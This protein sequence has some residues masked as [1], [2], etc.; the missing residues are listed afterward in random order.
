MG[1]M[2]FF[3]V[4]K[5]RRCTNVHRLVCHAVLFGLEAVA[6]AEGDITPVEIGVGDDV[7]TRTDVER[8]LDGDGIEFVFDTS[9]TG[10]GESDVA[11]VGDIIRP[12]TKVSTKT[13]IPA[14]VAGD[15]ASPLI[16]ACEADGGKAIVAVPAEVEF[17]AVAA[18]TMLIGKFSVVAL[19]ATNADTEVVLCVGSHRQY[20]YCCNS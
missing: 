13:G 6:D 5:T 20:E 8:K 15:F 11:V 14:E 7:E 4:K 16:D 12:E 18:E 17:E 9:L 10:N 2:F 19:S 1:Q 3:V